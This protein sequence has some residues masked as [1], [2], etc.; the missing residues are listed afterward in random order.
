MRISYLTDTEEELLTQ[1]QEL[2]QQ[3]TGESGAWALT[4]YPNSGENRIV[5]V[6]FG[7]IE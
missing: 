6:T 2:E 3:F 7:K 1:M 4:F 5:E